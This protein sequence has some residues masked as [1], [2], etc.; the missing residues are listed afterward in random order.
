MKRISDLLSRFTQLA[1][2]SDDAKSAIVDALK[3]VGITLK[4]TQNIKIRGGIVTLRLSPVQK[5]EIHFK[6][7]KIVE[8]LGKNPLTKNITV[9]R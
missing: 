1:Q 9:V 5:S 8:E 3:S 4:D 6:Q 7:K 2:N